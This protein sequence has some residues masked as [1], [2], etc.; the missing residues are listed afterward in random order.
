MRSRKTRRIGLQLESLETKNAPSAGLAGALH[1]AAEHR[2]EHAAAHHA[3]TSQ[4][5]AH[6]AADDNLPRHSGVDAA[7]NHNAGDDNNRN[8]RGR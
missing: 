1:H 5:Q 8:R 7:A 4:V 2:H 3:R 6:R